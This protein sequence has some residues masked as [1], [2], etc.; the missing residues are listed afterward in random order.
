MGCDFP[1]KDV[2][3]PF[4]ETNRNEKHLNNLVQLTNENPA[5][6]KKR[7]RKPLTKRMTTII[8]LNIRKILKTF[9][10]MHV[11]IVKRFTFQICLVSKLYF[12]KLP[13]DFLNEKKPYIYM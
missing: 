9:L 10:N 7:K 5:S 12:N 1:N 4:N 11:I 3:K 13:N 8:L 6:T 2:F